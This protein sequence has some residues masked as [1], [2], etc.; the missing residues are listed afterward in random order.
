[1]E[2]EYRR[3]K[4]AIVKPGGGDDDDVV[5][6]SQFYEILKSSTEAFGQRREAGNSRYFA[7]YLPHALTSAIFCRTI[8]R[9]ATRDLLALAERASSSSGDPSNDDRQQRRLLDKQNVG[10]AVEIARR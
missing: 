10:A 6:P 7:S 8:R 1:M 4:E 2:G 9:C 3:H 5:T